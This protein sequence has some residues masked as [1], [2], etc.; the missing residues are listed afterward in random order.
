MRGVDRH[1]HQAWPGWA[2]DLRDACKQRGG[3]DEEH[4]EC[5]RSDVAKTPPAM[6]MLGVGRLVLGAELVRRSDGRAAQHG[7]GRERWRRAAQLAIDKDELWADRSRSRSPANCN[8]RRAVSGRLVRHGR[9]TDAIFRERSEERPGRKLGQ[10][11][12]ELRV[13]EDEFRANRPELL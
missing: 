8:Q 3:E 7:A 4:R 11:T 13:D 9:R 12:A 6:R 1:R 5:E 10:K 2:D